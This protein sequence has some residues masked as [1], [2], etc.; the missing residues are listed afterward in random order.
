MSSSDPST[1]RLPTPPD[2]LVAPTPS[3]IS[4]SSPAQPPTSPPVSSIDDPNTSSNGN[5]GESQSLQGGA[6]S[7]RTG[8][9]A[10]Q[11]LTEIIRERWRNE[12]PENRERYRREEEE[13][14]QA[15]AARG[16][17]ERG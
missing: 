14:E 15:R 10:N 3:S 8:F 2:E 17:E 16:R 12:T 1:N 7:S 5:R 11:S 4:S 13:E 6:E 9:V